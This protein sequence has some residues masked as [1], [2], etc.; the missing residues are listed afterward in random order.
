MIVL[1]G[2]QCVLSLVNFVLL[3]HQNGKKK[4]V[5]YLSNFELCFCKFCMYFHEDQ[6]WRVERG[7]VGIFAVTYLCFE[8]Q[9]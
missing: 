9:Y 7:T 1:L 3:L 2:L 6:P 8:L 5:F 4:S